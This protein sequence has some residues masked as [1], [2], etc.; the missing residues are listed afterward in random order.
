MVGEIRLYQPGEE[1]RIIEVLE[2]VFDGWPAFALDCEATDHWRWR[3]ADNRGDPTVVVVYEVDGEIVGCVHSSAVNVRIGGEVFR[4]CLG[5]D[6]ALL[7]AHR[8][9]GLVKSL[10]KLVVAARE[11]A[12]ICFSYGETRNPRLL[13]SIRKT[14]YPLPVKTRHLVKIRNIREH[15]RSQGHRFALPKSLGLR[16]LA[17]AWRMLHRSPSNRLNG[18]ITVTALRSFG[19]RFE[20]FW[21]EVAAGYTWIVQRDRE[22]LN[23]RY[24]D[25]RAGAYEFFCAED[26]GQLLGYIVTRISRKNLDYP[27]AYIVDLLCLDDRLD[28][29]D[30][31]IRHALKRFSSRGI[32]AVHCLVPADHPYHGLLIC[33]GFFDTLERVNVFLRFSNPMQRQVDILESSAPGKIYYCYGDIDSI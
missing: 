6:T 1:E 29:A 5:G 14:N 18:A 23:W 31:L 15:L 3:Y 10:F 2:T 21:Q 32:N 16:T 11:A 22:Y 9:Q 17:A 30:A 20:S 26:E 19:Q 12:G 13:R 28:A 8:G 33:R 24:A 4:G 25:P 27:S 7:E